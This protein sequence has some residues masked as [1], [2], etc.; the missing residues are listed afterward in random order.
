MSTVVA[1]S[2]KTKTRR[3][4]RI[5]TVDAHRRVAMAVAAHPDDIEFLM[6]GTLLQLRNAG[7]SIHVLNLSRGSCGSLELGPAALRRTRLREAR[8]AARILGAQHHPPLCDDLEILYAMK[9]LRRL[10]AVVRKVAPRILLVPSPQDYMEDHVNAC[11]LAVTAGF[12]RGMPNFSALPATLPFEGELTVYHALPHGLRDG[13][14]RRIHP[15]AFVNTAP[16]HAIKLRALAAH[17]SQQGWLDASQKM[18]SYLRAME[19][20][21]RE[22]GKMSRRFELAEGWR[23]HSHLGFC[24]EKADPLR[25][26]L[27]SDFLVDARYEQEL[28]S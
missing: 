7:W 26:A 16:V 25:E 4:M 15:G 20:M 23:R 19:A 2:P 17:Q 1:S 10:A 5:Q 22:V 6:A 12:V 9:T 24:S 3:G 14:R 11:R 18:N 21:S 28:E 8:E 13:L 27:G